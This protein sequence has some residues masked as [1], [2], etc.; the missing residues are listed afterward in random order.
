MWTCFQVST[1]QPTW[2]QL[3]TQG[4]KTWRQLLTQG[5]NQ[6]Q[7]ANTAGLQDGIQLPHLE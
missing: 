5:F 3:L 7:P 6:L 4:F 2:R 1:S